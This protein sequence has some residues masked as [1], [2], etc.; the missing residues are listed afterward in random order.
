YYAGNKAETIEAIN[1]F[2]HKINKIERLTQKIDVY[3]AEVPHTHNFA[4]ASGVFVHNSAKA[5]RNRETQA[6]LPIFGKPLNTERAR[7]DKIVESDKFKYLIMAIGAGIGEHYNPKKLRYNKIILMSDADVDGMHIL[8]LYLT[9]FFRHMPEIL[10]SG[11]VYAA[12][13]PLFKGTWGKNKR[14][15]FDDVELQAFLKT[16]EGAKATVQ[17]FKGLGEMNAE[18]LWE[19]TMNPATRYL[20]QINSDDAAKADEVFTMLMG[21]EV[22][23]R[24]RFI[25]THAKQAL[26]D[27]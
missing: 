16:P 2:N 22:A 6:I 24:K 15:L 10:E 9:F 26:V 11:H 21:D 4:L 7:L 13:P 19:T 20:K 5:A 3:D 8:T 27:M 14:Y 18:E 12:M 25:M 17:R 1:H 23:P